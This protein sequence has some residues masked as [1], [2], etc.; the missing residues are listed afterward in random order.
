M[1]QKLSPSGE[2]PDFHPVV[3]PR[4]PAPLPW[5]PAPVVARDKSHLREL[6]NLAIN[7]KGI[8]VDLNHIDVSGIK[9]MDNLF[10][11]SLFN[12]DISEWDV[13]KVE[14]M[15][16]MF[17]RSKFNGDISRWNLT[18]VKNTA[19]MFARSAFNQDISTWT[20]PGLQ[21]AGSMFWGAAFNQDIANW[22]MARVGDMSNMFIGSHFRGDL[23]RWVIA[24][25]TTA[26]YAIDVNDMAKFLAPSIFH[27]HAILRRELVLTPT[28]PWEKHRTETQAL[29][30]LTGIKEPKD[31]A[32]FLQTTWI[33][34]HSPGLLVPDT[35]ELPTLE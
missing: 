10:D 31:I 19:F 13:S 14:T 9:D 22:D 24:D 18:S 7:A 21:R 30:D 20:F 16:S 23:S 17:I 32:A 12:G 27:W 1:L 3:T 26:H 6:I 2:L 15:H 8:N 33:G 5:E 25:S 35:F 11:S 29:M 4:A 34:K 28:H